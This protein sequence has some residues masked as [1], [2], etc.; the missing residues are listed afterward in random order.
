MK[1]KVSVVIPV[2]NGE[3][4][5]RQCLS[6]LLKQ[7]YRNYEIVIVNNNSTDRTKEIIDDFQSRDKRIKC[8]FECRKGRG[9]ARNVGLE[10]AKE[11]IIISTDSDCIF[12]PDWIENL[13]EPIR[14]ENEIAVQGGEEPVFIN[15]W[16]REAQKNT[17][18]FMQSLSEGK[19]IVHIDT[20]NFAI[21]KKVLLEFKTKNGIFNPSVNYADDLEFESRFFMKNHRVRYMP[22]CK[23]K[24][25]HYSS[26]SR[27]AKSEYGK[28][29]DATKIYFKMR[30]SKY[31]EANAFKC[32]G[33]LVEFLGFFP[34]H[35]FLWLSG[36]KTF[37]NMIYT[38]MQG[39]SWRAGVF[40]AYFDL[41][42]IK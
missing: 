15:F 3:K 5:L 18:L 34:W 12:Y 38:I 19:Y 24:H 41:K 6:S 39:C 33:S 4:T 37:A 11:K 10:S 14:K 40:M 13:T 31:A 17:D 8:I 36:R 9:N 16:T 27:L 29:Y 20:K 32:S 42:R 22:L 21:L 7:T 2:Y 25:Y 26:F 28:G 35:I 23:I 1:P 30:N